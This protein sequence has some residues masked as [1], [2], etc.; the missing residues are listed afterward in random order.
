MVRESKV[1]YASS[2]ALLHEEI[3][4][5][6]VEIARLQSV[7][8]RH[9][10]AVL[11]GRHADAVQQVVVYAIDL[12]I[13]ERIAVHLHRSGT[14][15]FLGA[16][17]GQLGRYEVRLARMAVQGNACRCLGLAFAVRRRRVEIVHAVLYG[18]IHKPIH[19]LLVYRRVVL[20]AGWVAIGG[21]QTHHAVAEQRDLVV[22]CRG[23]A[24]SH[25]SPLLLGRGR[26]AFRTGAS[27]RR[28]SRSQRARS[29]KFKERAACYL[30]FIAILHK[31][32][33]LYHSL[34]L[35]PLDVY[36]A[37]RTRRTQVLACAAAYAARCVDYWYFQ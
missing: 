12:K 36:C 25:R 14:R 10:L 30:A 13:L 4:H 19:L 31:A 18:V 29:H 17:V 37:E 22:G 2:L 21:R 34:H 32:M 15:P 11:F 16:E 27:D 9:L 20:L 8:S 28:R 6:V 1:A 26:L 35:V 33:F 3:E 24:I 23:Y 5:S 7:H